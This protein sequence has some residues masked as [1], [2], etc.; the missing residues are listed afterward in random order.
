MTYKQLK[1]KLKQLTDEQLNQTITFE[2]AGLCGDHKK[3]AKQLGAFFLF[4]KKQI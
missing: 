4:V 1:E 2:G 3:A